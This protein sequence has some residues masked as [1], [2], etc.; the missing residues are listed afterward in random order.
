MGA[1]RARGHLI[2]WKKIDRV[3]GGARELKGR[4]LPAGKPILRAFRRESQAFCQAPDL[5]P[6][7]AP[8][9][10][11]CRAQGA[12]KARLHARLRARPLPKH[13]HRNQLST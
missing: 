7:A 1:P 10:Q 3:L 5:F 6:K 13:Q 12:F 4:I 11:L 9:P 2:Q 8:Q